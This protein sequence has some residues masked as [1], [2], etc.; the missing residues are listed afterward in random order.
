MTIPGVNNC[1][2]HIGQAFAAD[3]VVGV[4]FGE[5]WISV[6][7]SVDYDKTLA[8][9]QQV[10]DGYPGIHRDV[11]TYLKER[12]REV[13]TGTGYSIVVRVYGDDLDTLKKQ[14]DKVKTAPR[15]HRGGHWSQSRPAGECS[16]GGRRGEP[17]RRQPLWPE[18]R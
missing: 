16:A 7:P 12:V 5:N 10:V 8:S 11:Q 3:E 6:D 15:R 17:G 1:G 4:N 9:I 13:L 14:A 18:A 2:S